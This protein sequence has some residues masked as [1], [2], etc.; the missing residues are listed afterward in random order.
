[1][2]IT[3]LE[4][5]KKLK[6]IEDE[7]SKL[8]N[9]LSDADVIKYSIKD[10]RQ[11]ALDLKSEFSKID[12]LQA[13]ENINKQ[14][15]ILKHALNEA[16]RT[17]M[18]SIG[19]SIADALVNLAQD[20]RFAYEISKSMPG[21]RNKLEVDYQGRY[22]EYLYDFDTVECILDGLKSEITTLQ[23]AIDV[24]NASTVVHID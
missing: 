17:T 13:I 9:K 4:L 10:D 20:Q 8:Y 21:T 11:L 15:R 22:I 16:N 12:I 14:E 6:E 23:L 7:K 2:D 19:I 5:K 18:T 24:A 1:M 3:I